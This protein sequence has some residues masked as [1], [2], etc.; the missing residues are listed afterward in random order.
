[1][2]PMKIRK[3]GLKAVIDGYTLIPTYSYLPPV[4][5]DELNAYSCYYVSECMNA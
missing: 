4:N 1:M 3:T 5:N 2:P